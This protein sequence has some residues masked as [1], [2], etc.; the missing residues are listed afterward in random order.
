LKNRERPTPRKTKPSNHSVYLFK[1][2]AINVRDTEFV[3]IGV[4]DKKSD[5]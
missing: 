5:E 3:S 1:R 2:G 4:P